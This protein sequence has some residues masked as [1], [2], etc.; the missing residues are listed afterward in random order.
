MRE[1]NLMLVEYYDGQK[2][3]LYDLAT[4]PGEKSDV[5]AQHPE[6]VEKMSA[7]LETWRNDLRV[8]RNRPNPDV[9]EAKAKELYTDIDASRFD[10]AKASQAQ[11]R[12][13]W[14]WRKKMNAALPKA[15]R[16][17]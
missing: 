5:A 3:E 2:S 14:D 12:G 8:Q 4:D 13:M 15:S 9:D 16:E 1:G 10:P 7:A 11:W 17:K 6:R